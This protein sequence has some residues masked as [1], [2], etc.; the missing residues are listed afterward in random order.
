MVACV[1]RS[2]SDPPQERREPKQAANWR[3]HIHSN[4]SI[5]AGKPVVRGSR[6]SAAFLLGL[7]AQGWTEQ[8][9]LESYPHISR[10]TV[11]AVFAFAAE[12][13]DDF[14]V[15]VDGDRPR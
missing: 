4:P 9:I 6:L 13:L 12:C 3:D 2:P 1:G 5:L 10:P 14:H 8:D 7:L 15:H 11:R